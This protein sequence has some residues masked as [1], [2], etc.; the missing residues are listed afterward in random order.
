MGTNLNE[1]QQTFSVIHNQLYP[2]LF[3]CLM[4]KEKAQQHKCGPMMSPYEINSTW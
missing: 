2:Q 1:D 3:P 4:Q